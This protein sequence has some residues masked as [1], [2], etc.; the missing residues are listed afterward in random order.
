MYDY[1]PVYVKVVIFSQT[2]YI[3]NGLKEFCLFDLRKT[4]SIIMEKVFP[5]N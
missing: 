2:W 5:S 3:C 1:F 4:I